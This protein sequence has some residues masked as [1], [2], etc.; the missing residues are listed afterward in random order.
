[1]VTVK[2]RQRDLNDVDDDVIMVT[3]KIDVDD[4]MMMMTKKIGIVTMMTL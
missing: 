2:I 1:M 4:V 3:G